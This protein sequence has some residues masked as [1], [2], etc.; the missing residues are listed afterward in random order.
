MCTRSAQP[1]LALSRCSPGGRCHPPSTPSR[2]L[3]RR[4]QPEGVPCRRTPASG[5][6]GR[7]RPG[8]DGRVKGRGRRAGLTPPHGQAKRGCIL[9]S[10]GCRFEVLIPV[11]HGLKLGT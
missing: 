2:C 10:L 1:V 8:G 4:R 11:A 5:G 7:S 9:L 6:G 3:L